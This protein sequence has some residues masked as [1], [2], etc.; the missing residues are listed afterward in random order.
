MRAV[1]SAQ[2]VI[3]LGDD[4][5]SDRG[6]ELAERAGPLGN[7]DAEDRFSRLADLRAFGHEPQTIEVHV[8]AAQDRHE[9]LIRDAG[10]LDP[11]PQPRDG[12]RS[13]R[14]HDRPRVV[15]DV[16]DRGADLVV[17]D[18]HDLFNRGLDDGEREPA[19][20]ANGDAIGED[21][22]AIEHDAPAGLERLIHGIRVE[23]LDADDANGRLERLDVAGDPGDQPAAADGHE[24]RR[25]VAE[26]VPKNLVTDRALP[27]DD[28]WI[29]EGM[30]ERQSRFGRQL[31][32][33]RL[34][35]SVA[36]ACQ[37]YFGAQIPYRL[38]FDLGRRLRHDDERAQ[39]EMPGRVGHALRVIACTGG[40][41]A[42]RTLGIGQVRDAVVR[43]PELVAEY[44]LQ[45]FTFQKHPVLQPPRK[46]ERRLERRFMGDVVDTAGEDQPQ[47]RFRRRGGFVHFAAQPAERE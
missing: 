44:R 29:V 2:P 35:V 25:H 7:R 40:N 9:R 33:A 37:D 32:A 34:G 23:R 36:V 22:H 1:P 42:A 14:F 21:A 10:A 46:E 18:A 38:D 11:R 16:L 30:H 5:A 39:A 27:G 20:F 47:H 43:A 41:D 45:I 28:Q 6:A 17:R 8:G 12:E 26:L 13:G 19:D 31:V 4:A 15:E 24:D 3:E